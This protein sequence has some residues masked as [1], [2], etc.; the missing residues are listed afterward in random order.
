MEEVEQNIA[1]VEKGPLPPELLDKL[2]QIAAQVPFRPC[3]E[4][5]VLPFGRQYRGPGVVR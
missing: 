3:E 2:D 5:A 4:P 1:A